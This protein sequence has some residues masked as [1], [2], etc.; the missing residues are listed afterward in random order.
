MPSRLLRPAFLATFAAVGVSLTTGLLGCAENQVSTN[1]PPPPPPPP[2]QSRS[3]PLATGDPGPS[4]GAG[5]CP[6]TTLAKACAPNGI[7]CGE[8]EG[9]GSNGYECESGRWKEMFTYCNPPP[10]STH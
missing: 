1:P 4:A 7:K 8:H 10:P 3:T 6:T 5:T 2:P 9:C